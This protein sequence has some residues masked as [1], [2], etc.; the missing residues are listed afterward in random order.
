MGIYFQFFIAYI[1]V[2]K[3][4]IVT[5]AKGSAYIEQGQTKAI[6]AVYGPRE[7]PRRSDFSMRGILN[8]TLEHTPY[9]KQHRKAP[10]AQK[11]DLEEEMSLSLGQALEATVCMVNYLP[12]SFMILKFM[13][14]CK[15]SI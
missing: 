3:T 14:C 7:I 8:C 1:L 5:K 2:L 11:D 13:N 6:C 9:A 12:L 15:M 10:E 4:G